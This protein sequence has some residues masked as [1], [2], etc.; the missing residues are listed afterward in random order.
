MLADI[1]HCITEKDVTVNIDG[2]K[3]VI[4]SGKMLDILSTKDSYIICGYE[5]DNG[6]YNKFNVNYVDVDIIREAKWYK[7]EVDSKIG[8]VYQ[9]FVT[10]Q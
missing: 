8:F 3:T 7:I 2:V 1:K 5:Q 6:N 9:K 10:L 4:L